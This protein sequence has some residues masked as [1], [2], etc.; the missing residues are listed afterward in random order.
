[1]F[2]SVSQISGFGRGYSQKKS[3]RLLIFFCF[4]FTISPPKSPKLS[5]IMKMV[6]SSHTVGQHVPSTLVQLAKAANRVTMGTVANIPSSS[7][8]SG[9]NSKSEGGIDFTIQFHDFTGAIRRI[10]NSG[11]SGRSKD[12]SSSMY[13][14][15]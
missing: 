15:S 10:R 14:S 3:H 6:Q 1:M 13:V 7:Q 2:A 8:W 5:G 12:E 11:H 9:K 4:F